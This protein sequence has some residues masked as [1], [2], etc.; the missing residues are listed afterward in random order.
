MMMKKRDDRL[1]FDKATR[2]WFDEQKIGTLTTVC[3][4]TNCNK[5]YK[6]E[7]GHKCVRYARWEENIRGNYCVV[8][9]DCGYGFPTDGYCWTDCN[10]RSDEAETCCHITDVRNYCPNCGCEMKED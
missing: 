5:L 1:F 3:L 6:P 8:C 10:K 2:E 4:C 7:L 9:S